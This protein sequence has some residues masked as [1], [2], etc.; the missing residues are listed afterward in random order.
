M[1]GTALRCLKIINNKYNKP[2]V[3]SKLFD[4]FIGD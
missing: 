3:L 2:D 1:L 4:R